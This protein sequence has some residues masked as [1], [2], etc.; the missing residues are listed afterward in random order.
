MES[1]LNYVL[2]SRCNLFIPRYY[3]IIRV[4]EAPAGQG[5]RLWIPACTLPTT[6][7]YLAFIRFRYRFETRKKKKKKKMCL[8]DELRRAVRPFVS[9]DPSSS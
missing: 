2:I 9:L 6:T 7:T 5:V 4:T 3:P 8:Q 1:K